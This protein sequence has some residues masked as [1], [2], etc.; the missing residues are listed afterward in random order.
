[1]TYVYVNQIC[2]VSVAVGVLS[3]AGLEMSDVIVMVYC[4]IPGCLFK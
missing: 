4:V 3:C 1:M 2:C